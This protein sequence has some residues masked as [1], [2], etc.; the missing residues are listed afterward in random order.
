MVEWMFRRGP[1]VPMMWLTVVSLVTKVE[2]MARRQTIG[3]FLALWALLVLPVL[4]TAGM[5]GHAC[6]CGLSAECGH[7]T[8]CSNDPCNQL[9]ARRSGQN[10][11]IAET[12]P[13]VVSYSSFA[14]GVPQ[15]SSLDIRECFCERASR[16]NLPYPDCDLPLL[17]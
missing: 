5:I 9:A 12:V 1:S 14:V 11:G 16:R 4:C 15:K 6:D 8:N 3:I 2:P 10:D 13:L 7:E 17:I